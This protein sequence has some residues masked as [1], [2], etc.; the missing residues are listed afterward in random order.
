[1]TAIDKMLETNTAVHSD[2]PESG[3]DLD[4]IGI[5]FPHFGDKTHGDEIV[6]PQDM[7]AYT[8]ASDLL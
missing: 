8:D 5:L 7:E 4:D 3:G 6:S 1:M 2:D